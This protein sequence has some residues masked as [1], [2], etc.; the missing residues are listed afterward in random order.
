MSTSLRACA[1]SMV[2]AYDRGTELYN[3]EFKEQLT[4][5]KKK[6]R[7]IRIIFVLI[8]IT[9]FMVGYFLGAEDHPLA[10]SFLIA[11]IPACFLAMPMATSS[12]FVSRPPDISTYLVKLNDTEIDQ[13]ATA[14]EFLFH[15]YDVKPVLEKNGGY[16]T[17]QE[18]KSIIK[19][20]YLSVQ[21]E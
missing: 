15:S 14:Y 16:V 21:P 8:A 12:L 3:E 19:M 9:L 4:D 5:Q 6:K 11:A 13:F 17:M 7:N 20:E 10:F 18:L 2:K 1:I